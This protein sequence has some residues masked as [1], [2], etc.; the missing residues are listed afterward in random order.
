MCGR[1][2]ARHLYVPHGNGERSEPKRKAPSAPI[3]EPATGLVQMASG[4]RRAERAGRRGEPAE[5]RRLVVAPWKS[6]AYRLERGGRCRQTKRTYTEQGAGG[7]NSPT[8][9]HRGEPATPAGRTCLMAP[10]CNRADHHRHPEGRVGRQQATIRASAS[11]PSIR[12]A[13]KRRA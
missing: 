3:P 13:W 2:Q 10:D 4:A 12:A 6:G 9:P 7:C 11:L 8:V 1:Q 5:G